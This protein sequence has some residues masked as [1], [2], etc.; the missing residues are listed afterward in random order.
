[1]DTV[2]FIHRNPELISGGLEI[3]PGVF[4]GGKFDNV[5]TALNQGL[6]EP[7]K[8]K[9]FI[10]YSGW[11]EGQLDGE[12]KDK[13]WILSQTDARLVFEPEEQQIWPLSLKNLGSTFAMMANYPTDPSLN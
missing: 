4:W 6:L 8:I 1:M 10:G 13:S 5:V 3:L 9:F 12:V 11:T 2:H 7:G